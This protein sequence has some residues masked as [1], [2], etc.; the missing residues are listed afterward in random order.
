MLRLGIGRDPP[1]VVAQDDLAGRL[2]DD[3]IGAD[4]HL[5]AASR[6]VD[7]ECGYGISRGVPA[8][9]LDDLDPFGDGSAEVLNAFREVA[10]IDIVGPYPRLDQL[11]N[12]RLLNVGA[13]VD[14]PEQDGLVAERHAGVGEAGASRHRLRSQF[15]WVIEMG[16]DPDRMVLSDHLTKLFGDPEGIGDRNPRAEPDDLDVVDRAQA[17]DDVFEAGV[18][19]REGISPRDQDVSDLGRRPDVVER[20]VDGRLGNAP[21]L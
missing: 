20:G 19:Q 3:V 6:R 12:E 14:A 10:L 16:V 9:V 13:V 7:H 17:G 5:A 15:V 18:R 21:F 2:R 1:F 11:V 4:G 8:Q